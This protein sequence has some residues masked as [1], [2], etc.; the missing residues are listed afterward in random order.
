[1]KIFLTGATGFIGIH[2]LRRLIDAGHHVTSLLLPGE[3]LSL[4]QGLN[5][6]VARGDITDPTGLQGLFKG[7]DAVIHLAGAVG[8]GQTMANCI[9][10]NV[11][12]T[13]T[14]A[15]AAA[16]E[17]ARRFIHF[18]SVSVYGR[19]PDVP[20]TEDFPRK[21]I[22][23]PYGDTKIMAE[24]LLE[25]FSR[26]GKLDVTM[27]RPT[28]IY[29]PGDRLFLPKLVENV[30]SGRARI[31]GRGDNRV[32]LVH[33]ADVADFAALLL[34]S[35]GTSGRV[36]NLT[37]RENPTWKEFLAI[38]AAALG[39]PAPRKHMPYRA[40]LAVA[41]LMEL[42]AALTKRPPLLTRYSVRVVG[43]AYH[44]ITDR[45]K[46]ELGF[47]PR[48]DLVRGITAAIKDVRAGAR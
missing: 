36:Y 8:Y 7:H 27:I 1:M 4:L 17:G 25:D 28:V 39:Y 15:G 22:G 29:G 14:V 46:D 26:R 11:E 19:V 45:A 12:G 9:R 31:I 32:D 5:T 16:A 40:A 3:P 21:K 42:H 20:V 33:V 10:L 18:S 41:A 23:D 2:V 6:A 44:Y 24:E 48:I 30:R 37:N 38:I 47:V 34:K 13:R 35:P 43:R